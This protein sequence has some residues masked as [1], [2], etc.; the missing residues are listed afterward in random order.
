MS[1]TTVTELTQA[2]PTLTLRSDSSVAKDQTKED[3]RSVEPASQEPYRYAHLLPHFSQEHYPPLTP[4]DHIDPGARALSHPNPRAFLDN[5]TSVVELTPSLGTE[6]QGISLADL[7]SNGRDELALEVCRVSWKAIIL[8]YCVHIVTFR[9]QDEDW[10]YSGTNKTL[11][12]E[13][14]SSIV[15][16]ESILAGKKHHC[17]FVLPNLNSHRLHIHPTSGHPLGYPEFHLVYRF[18]SMCRVSLLYLH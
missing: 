6:V 17:L 8:S 1:T 13:D 10:W 5:A 11:L 16:G 15:N 12:T 2:I 18:V 9:S 3:Q 7:D 4:F 14:L